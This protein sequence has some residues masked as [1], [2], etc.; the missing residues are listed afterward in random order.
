M[1]LIS[2]VCKLGTGVWGL[3]DPDWAGGCGGFLE[4]RIWVSNDDLGSL[5]SGALECVVHKL[6]DICYQFQ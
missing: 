2:L 5:G 3:E 4:T 1:S 6:E